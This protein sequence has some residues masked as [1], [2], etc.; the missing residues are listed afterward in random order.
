M[1][2]VGAGTAVKRLRSRGEIFE[3]HRRETLLARGTVEHSILANPCG[4]LPVNHALWAK[5][6]EFRGSLLP[7]GSNPVRKLLK[8][9]ALSHRQVT[10]RLLM[11]YTAYL[12]IPMRFIPGPKVNFPDELDQSA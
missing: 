9:I 3:R 7:S 8:F 4:W 6:L 10:R 12:N 2:T 11:L 5:L 1:T